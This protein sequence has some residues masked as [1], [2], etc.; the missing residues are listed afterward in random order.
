MPG[1]WATP[2]IRLNYPGISG[3]G[4]ESSNTG[5]SFELSVLQRRTRMVQNETRA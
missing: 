2:V 5:H 3:E 1:M 4:Q